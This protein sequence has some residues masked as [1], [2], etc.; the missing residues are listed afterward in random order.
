MDQMTTEE[1]MAVRDM[2]GLIQVSTPEPDS[3]GL[4]LF[5]ATPGKAHKTDFTAHVARAA[6]LDT[7]GGT[8]D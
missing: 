5:H 2:V 1:R 6:S 3:P 4:F 8:C 7:E